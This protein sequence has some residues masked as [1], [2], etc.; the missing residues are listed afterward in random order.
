VGVYPTNS[1]GVCLCSVVCPLSLCV[2]CMGAYMCV[3]VLHNC[4][5]YHNMHVCIV[6]MYHVFCM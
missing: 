5:T 3:C 6:D 2:L 1:A 4:S